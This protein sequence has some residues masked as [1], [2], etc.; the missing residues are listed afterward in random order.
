MTQ[1]LSHLDNIG[2]SLS[3]VN[4]P[5]RM[6]QAQPFPMK[7]MELAQPNM[8][9]NSEGGTRPG[10]RRGELRIRRPMNAFMVW[11]KSERKK[12]ADEN[13]DVHNADLSKI[14]GEW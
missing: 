14:L 3:M 2:G 7:W 12:L 5:H 11:A 9:P 1:I 13:P 4:E 6:M 8:V 10:G